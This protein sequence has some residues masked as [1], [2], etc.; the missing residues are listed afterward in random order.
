MSKESIV[1]VDTGM[2]L[3]SR[4]GDSKLASVL[5]STLKKRKTLPGAA[6]GPFWPAN[7][8]AL[9]QCSFFL[10]ASDSEQDEIVSCCSA[11]VLEETYY[12]E[13]A[14]MA[15]AAKMV[16][17]SK[18]VEERM[19]YS[20]FASD[21]ATHFE[22]IRRFVNEADVDCETNPFL[23]LLS[24]FIAVGEPMALQFVVQIVLEGWGVAYYRDLAKGCTDEPLRTV[25][26]AIVR[27]EASHHG[28]G[29]VLFREGERSE[30]VSKQIIEVMIKFLEMVQLG[31]QAV[32]AAIDRVLGPLSTEQ[33]VEIFE[34]LNARNHSA[35]RL[36][37][38]RN[39]ML[40]SGAADIV[41]V[42]EQKGCFTAYTPQECVQ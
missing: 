29:L 41:E 5:L 38:L 2:S 23:A 34:E 10:N 39:L 7:F 9:D 3:P 16:L 13:K 28:S 31:P 24:G 33:R 25:F 30:L 15:F 19:L 11:S 1:H 26:D 14:G 17:L 4:E 18:T 20:L 37:L 40:K 27:D 12:I 42:L 36:D 8:F 21:E 6:K 32:C 35:R 22:L